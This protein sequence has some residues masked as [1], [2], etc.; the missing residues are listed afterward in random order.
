MPP[1]VLRGEVL[2]KEYF[3]ELGEH[4]FRTEDLSSIWLTENSELPDETRRV[5]PLYGDSRGERLGAKDFGGKW[6]CL[7]DEE[8]GGVE[9]GVFRGES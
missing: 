1:F 3:G 8:V 4:F 2:S 5:H 7:G 9:Q 6:V